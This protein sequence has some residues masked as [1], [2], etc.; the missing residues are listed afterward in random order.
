V[1]PTANISLAPPPG[2]NP[3]YRIQRDGQDIAIE[4]LR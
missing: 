2:E 3:P 4:D 1:P